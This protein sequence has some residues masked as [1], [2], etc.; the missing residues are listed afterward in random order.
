KK[1]KYT[2][3]LYGGNKINVTNVIFT[4]GSEDLWRELEV[5]KSTNP[6]SKAILIDGASECSD[7]D[8]SDS[9][10]DSP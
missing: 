1:V 4:Q 10:Y 2:N 7:I 5:T 6:T 8:D 9:E 3:E